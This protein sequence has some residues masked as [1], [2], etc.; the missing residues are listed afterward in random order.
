MRVVVI[1]QRPSIGDCLLLGP[2]LREIKT[3]YP[4][5]TLTVITDPT[6]M[7]GALLR[8]FRGI[9][10][11]DRIESIPA[12]EWTTKRNAEIQPD[13]TF[14]AQS[15][16][17]P[18]VS[19]ANRVFDCNADFMFY[20]REQGENASYGIAEFWLRHHKLYR[21]GMDL[22]PVYSVS[23]EAKAWAENWLAEQGLTSPVGIV[24][25]AGAA[26]RDWNSNGKASLLCDWMHTRG[27]EPLTIDPIQ[28]SSSIYARSLIG[29]PLDHVAAVI[30][31]CKLLVVPDTGLL[32]LAQAVGTPTVA[33]WGIMPPELRVA[34]YNTVVVPKRCLGVCLPEERCPQCSWKF[35]RW[36]CPRRI[37]IT[38]IID[39]VEEALRANRQ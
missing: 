38:H 26:P 25:R 6:Y 23:A 15:P 37:T 10:G 17:P 36:S 7:G 28:K 24:L 32:H 9:P 14:A 11:I 18:T 20:E 35:Q 3:Q 33:L 21:P 8:V 19:K 12:T 31:K 4:K 2:L 16:F 27:L 22:M 34:G 1:R 5:C 29:Q 13:L 39:G 30:E